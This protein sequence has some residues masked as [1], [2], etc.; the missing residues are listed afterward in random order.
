[1]VQ[2][3]VP[4]STFCS[5]TKGLSYKGVHLDEDGPYLVG[6]GTIYE[7]GGFK[8]QKLR[9]YSGPHK[10]DQRI[11]PGEVYVAMTNMAEET[12]RFLGSTAKF[13][14]V[15]NEYGILTHHVSKVSW[16]TVDPLMQEFLFWVMRSQAFHRHCRN[17]GTGTTVHAVKGRDAERFLVPASLTPELMAWAHLLSTLD[18]QEQ[19]IRQQQTQLELMLKAIFKAW[20]VDFSPMKTDQPSH[21]NSS[22]ELA[23]LYPKQLIETQEGWAPEGWETTDLMDIEFIKGRVPRESETAPMI[24]LLNM[25]Y[26]KTGTPTC[27]PDERTTKVKKGDVVMLMD[28]E[29]SGFTARSPLDAAIG[30]TF[31]HLRHNDFSDHFLLHVLLINEYWV[32]RN[33]TGTGIPHVDKEIVRRLSFPRPP[34]PLLKRFDEKASAIYA[35]I[36]T[37]ENQLVSIR[38]KK[39]DLAGRYDVEMFNIP[40]TTLNP[41]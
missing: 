19:S 31:A 25:D 13:P 14:K 40:C 23:L 39:E 22:D 9:T 18:S 15:D 17:Y 10:V 8:S 32:R 33:T 37:L 29:N 6:I 20:F 36:E 5:F 26:F 28:G 16:K 7:G 24:S 1:M 4:L 12:S 11:Y 30:S 38:R 3:L 27:I 34:A 2:Q 41:L 21:H 35:Q